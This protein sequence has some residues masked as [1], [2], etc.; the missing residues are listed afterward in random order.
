MAESHV[1]RQKIQQPLRQWLKSFQAPKYKII[2][3]GKGLW[4]HRVQL[5]TKYSDN[6]NTGNQ[7]ATEEF[8]WRNKNL[9]GGSVAT[10]PIFNKDKSSEP[11]YSPV[12]ENGSQM[13]GV[14]V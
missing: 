9:E 11:T 10:A 1:G 2:K 3:V 7:T 13:A 4:G 8:L 5:V 14:K 6:E 12:Q